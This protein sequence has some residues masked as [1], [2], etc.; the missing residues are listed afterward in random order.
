M[1]RNNH[2]YKVI[3]KILVKRK[4]NSKHGLEFMGPFPITQINDNG[5]VRLQKGII[6]DAINIRIIKHSSTS[7]WVVP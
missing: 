6:N 5:T 7:F 4:K 2:Q 3:D 1:R